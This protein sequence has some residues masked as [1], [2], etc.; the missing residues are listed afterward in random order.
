[1][2]FVPL[3]GSKTTETVRRAPPGAPVKRTDQVAFL[4]ALTVRVSG[5]T[6]SELGTVSLACRRGRRWLGA[7]RLRVAGPDGEGVAVEGAEDDLVAAVAVEVGDHGAAGLAEVLAR[8]GQLVQRRGAVAAVLD[9]PQ[10]AVAVAGDREVDVAVAVEVAVPEDAGG[11][12]A[13]AVARR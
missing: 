13:E 4:P 8:V 12:L 1:M 11:A 9:P 3:A 7:V 5:P 2:T 10:A 6:R